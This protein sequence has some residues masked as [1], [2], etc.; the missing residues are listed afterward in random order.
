MPPA[1]GRDHARSLSPNGPS[2]Q[3]A[4]A[5]NRA[6]VLVAPG[7]KPVTRGAQREGS[8]RRPVARAYRSGGAIHP[9]EGTLSP[10]RVAASASALELAGFEPA[11]AS[12]VRSASSTVPGGV[13]C[14]ATGSA[15]AATPP[16]GR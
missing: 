7:L 13:S 12:L 15:G 4:G 11:A 3:L 14:A 6:R 9:V 8:G 2:D 1:D 16:G 5:G 10:D